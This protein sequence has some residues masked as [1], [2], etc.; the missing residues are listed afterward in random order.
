MLRSKGE[1][2]KMKMRIRTFMP[3]TYKMMIPYLILVLFT[4]IIIGYFSYSL[5]IES[6]TEMA[7]TNIRTAMEQT[8]NN[9]EYQM[10][11]I[12]RMSDTLFG[13]L[14]FQRALQKKGDPWETYLTMLDE[15]VPQIQAPLKLYGNKIRL[16]IY[17][18]NGYLNE[19]DG[20][21]LNQ[22]IDDSDYYVLPYSL[23]A[24]REWFKT[25][26]DSELDNL[27]MQVD[28]DVKLENIS[29][30]RRLVSFNDYKTG[31]GYVR[32]TT[33]LTD[34]LGDF[35][36]F[37]IE[38]G[39]VLRLLDE[40]TN[41]TMYQ[42]G[43]TDQSINDKSFLILRET[44]PDTG[45]YIETLVPY[46]Y[47]EKDASRL[48]SVI[49][50][51]CS[52]SFLVM[53]LIG[54]MVARLSGRKM[55][56]IVTQLR[57]FQEGN[58]Q[59]RI[60]F[61]GNDEFVHIADA[62]NIMAGNIQELIKSVYVHGIQKKQAE[63]EALQAQINPHFLYNTL[64]TISSL[65]NLGE[66]QKVTGMVSGLAK[67]YRLSL[68]Q[69]N[70]YIPLEKELE[71]IEAYLDIQRIK[72]ADAFD[73]YFDLDP[74]L[75]DCKVI[76]LIL[77]PFVENVFKHAWFGERISI[78][79]S[80]KRIGERMELKVIDDGIGMK[81]EV[82]RQLLLGP[83]QSGG[84]YGLKNVDDRIKLRYGDEFG[85]QIGS[86]YGGG[87]TIRIVLPIDTEE[88]QEADEGYMP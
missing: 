80:A 36:T 86:I 3:F 7:E 37:P 75:S 14:S 43:E 17:T 72:Y 56:R 60:R 23:I 62:F 84:G 21:N 8:R 55:K 48:Q 2:A 63:L 49:F 59:K 81:P 35:G 31:I 58:F 27:W 22:Q 70:V 64:S 78:R 69:G 83:S 61:S 26:K 33:R 66:A 15:I 42:R 28:T 16:I 25:L 11:E 71:Q 40:S 1:A 82:A 38:D 18:T 76:K 45:L 68:N 65:A 87:T 12:Q 5:L 13:S 73:V 39:I 74:E 53:A 9:L 57:S 79:I 41:T 10:D 77:Q 52:I 6:R 34:L 20:D 24:D 19:V 51:I 88:K 67:F 32:I 47:L 29:H 44:I 4:D 50:A 30:V 85:I 46:S 54:Y